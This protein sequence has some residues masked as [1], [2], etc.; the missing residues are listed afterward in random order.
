MPGL[1]SLMWQGGA[2]VA[3]PALRLMLRQRVQRGKELAAR[4]PE[5]EGIDT[6]PRPPGRLMWIHAASVGE[7]LSVLS[8]LPFLQEVTVLLTTGTVTSAALLAGRLPALETGRV[9]H[10]FVPLDVPAWAARFLD[11]WQ[12]N[13]AAFVESELWPNTLAACQARRIPLMLINARMSERSFR[14]WSRAPRFARH[15]LGAFTQVQAQSAADA[16]RLSALGARCVT[17]PGDLKL[18]A[19][20]LEADP[21]ALVQLRYVIGDRPVWLAASTHPGEEAM[22]STIHRLLAP[23]YPGLLTIIAPRHPDRGPAIEPSAPHRSDGQGPEGGIWVV[24]TLG[25]LGLLYRLTPIVFVG[26]SLVAPGGGQ[27][28]WE[29][30]KLGCVVAVGPHTGNFE[31]AVQ[32]LR[33]AG[34]LSVVPDAAGLAAWVEAMLSDPARVTAA[35]QAARA[36]ASGLSDLPKATAQSLLALLP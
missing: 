2:S 30:A 9:M 26:R 12:P 32:K 36:V 15:V 16:A 20:P 25:E 7:S 1:T 34:V 33:A 4:L 23:A 22:A 8:V 28:P 29:P 11:H 18:A 19:P 13:A 35:G 17:A 21:D 3:A 31:P 24:D 27:N 14:G 5:R 6:T 10:R